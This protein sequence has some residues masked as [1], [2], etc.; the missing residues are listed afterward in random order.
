MGFADVVRYVGLVIALVGTFVAS[1]A[2]V[3]H[4]LARIRAGANRMRRSAGRW[5][6]ALREEPS[7]PITCEVRAS[8]PP[9]SV[10]ARGVVGWTED[11][12]TK[13]KFEMLNDRTLA[14]DREMGEVHRR[15]HTEVARINV[16]IERVKAESI[17]ADALLGE[18]ME[19]AEQDAARLDARALPVIV[20]GLLVSGMT[21]E[22]SALPRGLALLVLL[23]AL[24]LSAQRSWAIVRDWRRRPPTQR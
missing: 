3:A 22:I 1:P 24:V 11:A 21:P 12:S 23:A 15:I 7:A 6:R 19:K 10:A 16:E 13:A 14:L 17:A 8:L 9:L 5:I 2:G 4:T 20:G 18:R